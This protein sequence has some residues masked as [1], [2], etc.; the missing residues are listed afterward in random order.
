MVIVPRVPAVALSL[1]TRLMVALASFFSSVRGIF[2]P[3]DGLFA[4]GGRVRDPCRLLDPDGVANGHDIFRLRSAFPLAL[5]FG[6]VMVTLLPLT[7]TLL[8]LPV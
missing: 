4:A 8:G 1:I 3:L 6:T 7:T 2:L 5:T